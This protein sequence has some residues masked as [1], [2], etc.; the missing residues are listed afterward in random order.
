MAKVWV[1]QETAYDFGSAET[2]GEI[3][4][5]TNDDVNNTRGSLHNEALMRQI[6]M[7]VHQYNEDEDFVIIAGSPY[8]AAL[9]FATL[10]RKGV[11]QIKFLR[12][13]NRDRVYTPVSID[14]RTSNVIDEE[15]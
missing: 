10:G 12:W 7:A 2:Y 6:R 13:S 3:V 9:V 4:F 8:V 1:T 14:L 5:I 11:S 15:S